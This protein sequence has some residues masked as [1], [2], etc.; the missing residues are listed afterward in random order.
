MSQAE[1]SLRDF[2]DQEDPAA[3][4][5]PNDFEI[6][7]LQ[8]A[9]ELNLEH[10]IHAPHAHGWHVTDTDS[11]I[12]AMRKI[13]ERR[14]ELDEI[15]AVYQ[16]QIQQMNLWRE[17][18]QA[19]LL[20]SITYFEGRLTE[21]HQ[22]KLDEDPTKKTIK[23]PNG[24]LTCRKLPDRIEVAETAIEGLPEQFLRV[25]VEPKKTEL[26]KHIKDTGELFDG[27]SVIPGD[28]KFTVK[29]VVNGDE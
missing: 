17:T 4:E 9:Q 8:A 28:L 1:E 25:K 24:E 12:W 14:G 10:D 13:Q 5:I 2:L 15:E 6:E 22:L 3:Q 16:R 27:V 20:R 11:A 26:L 29:P 19:R 18:E 7:A 23:L 21:Y